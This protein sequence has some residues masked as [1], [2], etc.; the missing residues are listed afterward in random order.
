LATSTPLCDGCTNTIIDAFGDLN[1]GGTVNLNAGLPLYQSWKPE[2]IYTLPNGKTYAFH[3]VQAGTSTDHNQE[4][5]LLDHSESYEG[6]LP[7]FNEMFSID[8][9]EGVRGDCSNFTWVD[10]AK[11]KFRIDSNPSRLTSYCFVGNI[12]GY[13]TAG[14][15]VWLPALYYFV[16][17]K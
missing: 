7:Q 3:P 17:K 15:A 14:D 13:M 5:L 9:R 16:T 12:Q 6:T 1:P 2:V 10:R 4:L 8:K 11:G